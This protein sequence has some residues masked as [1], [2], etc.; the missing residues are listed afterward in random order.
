MPWWCSGE[1]CG[2]QSLR[3]ENRFLAWVP[4]SLNNLKVS[5]LKSERKGLRKTDKSRCCSCGA[6]SLKG[7]DRSPAGPRALLRLFQSGR[8]RF[9]RMKKCGGSAFGRVV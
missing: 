3:S 4:S 8:N 7:E 9:V 5:S 1:G 6:R 2:A